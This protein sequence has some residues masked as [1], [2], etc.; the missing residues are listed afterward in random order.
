MISAILAIG[1]L[2]PKPLI[3]QPIDGFVG[4]EWSGIRIGATTDGDI[5][6]RFGTEKGAIRPEALNVK[7]AEGTPFRVDALLDGRGDKAKVTALRLAYS[8]A[9]P[10]SDEL[11]KILSERPER[12]YFE[13]RL[14]DWALDVFETR[15]IGLF[16]LNDRTSVALLV[17]PAKLDLL[18]QG[19][20]SAPTDIEPYD[21]T[22]TDDQLLVEYGSIDVY[23]SGSKVNFRSKRDIENDIKDELTRR[24]RARY[25]DYDRRGKARMDARVDIRYDDRRQTF[26]I[27][28]RLTVDGE[29]AL[30]RVSASGGESKRWAKVLE[31]PRINDS[32]MVLDVLEKARDDLEDEFDAAVRKQRPPTKEEIRTATWATLINRATSK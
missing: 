23:L 28:V 16:V 20:D 30:G 29:N 3:P 14:E 26:T 5:K 22:F 6:R 32:R 19:L 2:A 18:T 13:G 10:S 17:P 1:L 15:G 12:F 25:L 7:V 21:P 11:S 24:S 31:A 8:G 27:D 9:G 4:N